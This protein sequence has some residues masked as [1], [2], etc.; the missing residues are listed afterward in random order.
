MITFGNL[1]HKGRLG[2]QLFQIA[3]MVGLSYKHGH[4]VVL[5]HWNYCK[6]FKNYDIGKPNAPFKAI[7][8]KEKEF[9]HTEYELQKNQNYDFDGYFQSARYW[10][11][12][13]E[14]EERVKRLFA[15]KQSYLND[16]TEKYSKFLK[17]GKKTIA[18]SVRRGDYV[19]NGNYAQIPITYYLQALRLYFPGWD[20]GEYEIMLFSDD[21]DY[22]KEHFGC[23]ENIHY[24]IQQPEEYNRRENY[25]KENPYAM[26]QLALMTLCDN[27]IISNSTFAWWGAYLSHNQFSTVVTPEEHF[28]GKLL[29]KCNARDYHLHKWIKVPRDRYK[30]PLTRVTFTIPVKYDHE[31]RKENLSLNV[32]TLQLAFDTNIIIGEQGKPY[33]FEEFKELGCK[34]IQYPPGDFHRTRMLNDMAKIAGGEIVVNWD[35]DVFVSPVQIYQAVMMITRGAEVV[36]PYDGRFARVPREYW[37]KQLKTNLDVGI[38]AG[39][40]FSGIDKEK[41]KMSVGGAI[42]FNKKIF[43][44]GGGENE[45]FITYGPEDAERYYRFEKL[46]YVVKRVSGILY[47]MD[48]WCGPDS[49]TKNKHIE[50]N[51]K[52]WHKVREMSRPELEQYVMSW[53]W[54]KTYAY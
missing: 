2:N 44:D 41:D 19:Q 51:R 20:D 12:G 21:I 43:F 15:F 23:Y 36:Y 54:F 18:I 47:H 30:I 45:Y 26:E 14:P 33:R 31:D 10:C 42:F 24:S 4:E 17:A 32:K 8:V 40:K 9:H 38:F 11:Y 34:Y 28:A 52:E 16:I 53:P 50:K 49:S 35:A 39:Y 37:L 22:C 27:H 46:G 48:H 29:S 5:P 3:S 1:G 6:Y 13:A 7:P 25:F